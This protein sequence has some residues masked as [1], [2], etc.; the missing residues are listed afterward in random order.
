MQLTLIFDYSSMNR[1]TSRGASGS[2]YSLLTGCDDGDR[3]KCEAQ[4]R[5]DFLCDD[6]IR[7]DFVSNQGGLS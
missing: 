6:Y 7:V 1:T 4:L 2:C 5:L 3:P